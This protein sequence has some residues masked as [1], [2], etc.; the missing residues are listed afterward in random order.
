MIIVNYLSIFVVVII[1]LHFFNKDYFKG[2]SA[3]LFFLVILPQNMT[4]EFNLS[5]PALTI[6]RII[7]IIMIIAWS[8]NKDI[9]HRIK[10]IPFIS[11]F[12]I[13][14]YSLFVSTALSSNLL[15]SGKRFLYFLVENLIF[16]LILTTSIRDKNELIK[17]S[18]TIAVSLA[19]VAILGWIEKYSGFNPTSLLPA[20]T[21]Y[22]FREGM[23]RGQDSG[24]TATYGHRILFGVAMSVSIVYNLFLPF[25]MKTKFQK[26]ICWL[27]VFLSIAAL[28]YSES[29]G[30]WLSIAIAIIFSFIFLMKFMFK[31]IILFSVLVCVLLVAR[32]GV[33]ETIT[34]LFSSTLNASSIKGSSFRWRFSILDLAIQQITDTDTL[35]KFL[36]GFGVGSRHYMAEDFERINLST[37]HSA[38][39]YSWDM[40]YAIILFERGV[41]GFLLLIYLYYRIIKLGGTYCINNNKTRELMVFSMACIIIFMFMKTNVSIYIPQLGYLELISVAFISTLL[42]SK[43]NATKIEVGAHVE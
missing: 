26:Y 27:F 11:I 8:R 15:V 12:I 34:G 28:Y 42:T 2:L 40:E 36:F 22:A 38:A 43:N 6:H 13:M 30:P 14:T 9:D 41:V 10:N 37:G 18:I 4:I 21:D 19:I 35:P 32:P 25:V 16:F 3:S 1:I 7:L 23:V 39:V 31:K 5:L 29:R 17:I 24:V 33:Y 20:K